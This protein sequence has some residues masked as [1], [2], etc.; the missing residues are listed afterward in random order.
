MLENFAFTLYELFGYLLPGGVALLGL[1]LLY[2]SVFISRAPLALA[3]FRPGFGT[4]VA[5]VVTGYILGHAV[6]ALG[7][8][9]LRR[10]ERSVLAMDN[11]GWIRELAKSA[12]VEV[13]GAP[14]N[15]LDGPW[16]YR[17]LDEYS[18]QNAKPGDRDM[19]VYR[20]GFYRG[21]CISLFFLALMTLVRAFVPNAVI[22]FSSSCYE[23]TRW[24]LLVS[25][26]ITAGVGWLF[27]QRYRRFTE[28]RINRAV[29]SALIV[30]KQLQSTGT[31]PKA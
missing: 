5:I 12:A 20:E 26:I 8:K 31:A 13:S 1:I 9:L 29:L 3:S 11:A 16:V 7:N 2:W 6:Q 30:R 19:F 17:I 15:S 21:T 4:W 14:A 22:R 18:T 23:V 28:Y 25:T 10:I 24:E 27:L